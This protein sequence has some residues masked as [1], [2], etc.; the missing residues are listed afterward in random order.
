MRQTAI[1]AGKDSV[2]IMFI[3]VSKV[4]SLLCLLLL[5]ATVCVADNVYTWK[6]ADGVVHYGDRPLTHDSHKVD[7][8]FSYQVD[9]HAVGRHERREKILK[10]EQQEKEQQDKQEKLAKDKSV[11]TVEKCKKAQ[12][13][14]AGYSKA[15]FL[16]KK[17]EQGKKQILSGADKQ[18][19][20]AEV[21]GYLQKWCQ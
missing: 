20:M 3:S 17:D 14:Y 9:S 7:T 15:Q 18:K 5:F 8:N 11:Q 13:M 4:C 19:A 12:K 1:I 21:Q 10:I 6:D 2:N 16:Y